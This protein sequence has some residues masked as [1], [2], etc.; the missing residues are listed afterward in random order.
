VAL[1][2]HGD[3]SLMQPGFSSLAGAMTM[4][5]KRRGTD[6]SAERWERT[7]SGSSSMDALH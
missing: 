5:S 4:L 7:A 3:G 6:L 1:S 2:I